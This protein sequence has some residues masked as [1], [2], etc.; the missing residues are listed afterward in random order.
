[1]RHIILSV[2]R[3]VTCHESVEL[4]DRSHDY[5]PEPVSQGHSFFAFQRGTEN[6]GAAML[7][8]HSR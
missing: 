7:H 3:P 4:L 8:I 5:H 6:Q 1:M 2:L